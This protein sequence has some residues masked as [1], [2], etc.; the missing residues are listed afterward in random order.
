M[1]PRLVLLIIQIAAAW[2]LAEPIKGLLPQ[3]LGRQ[4]DIFIYAL[5]YAAIIMLVGF[6]GALVL[7]SVRVPTLATFVFS[8]V[9]AF[10]LAG[11]TLIDPVRNAIDTAVPLLRANH[12]VYALAGAMLGYLFKR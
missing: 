4:Y 12:K 5:I 2:F 6:V 9:I 3:F 10:V 11:L 1:L 8:V 7:K